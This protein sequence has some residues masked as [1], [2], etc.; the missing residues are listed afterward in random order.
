MSTNN[1]RYA[2][3]YQLDTVLLI[4]S[5][6]VHPLNKLMVELNLYEDILGDTISGQL[7]LITSLEL[8]VPSLYKYL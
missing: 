8:M 7:M 4:T 1:T 5:L 3:E 6:G 2:T